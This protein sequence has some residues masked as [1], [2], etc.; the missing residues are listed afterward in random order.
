MLPTI[1]L[2]IAGMML[3]VKGADYLVDG[4]S[5]IATRLG[6]SQ[7]VIGL[8]IV[9]FGTSAP[10]LVV[11]LLSALQGQADIAIGNIN[12][13]NIANVLLILGVTAFTANVPVRG[14]TVLREI[15]LMILSLLM[16]FIYTLDNFLL[17]EPA[18]LDRTEGISLLGIFSIFVYM[19][20]TSAAQKRSEE[21]DDAP[22]STG[23]AIIWSLGGLAALLVGGS[24]TVDSAVQLATGLG[25]SEGLIA[26]TIVA[27]GTSLPELAT[28]IAAARKKKLD[29]AVGNIVGSNIF[30]VLMVLGITATASPE[31]LPISPAVQLDTGFALFA[32]VTLYLLLA[33][34]YLGSTSMKLSKGEGLVMIIMYIAYIAFISIRG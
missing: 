18:M 23:K 3:L 17:G 32:G 1:I 2:L 16:L 5:S 28:S 20:I 30:N 4:S 13:S 12:G 24:L 29:L 14:K 26:V 27:L 15:P 25:V 21:A 19:M 8:T 6:V 31:A 7:L 22:V 34:S 9:A 11:N 10:E 33:R